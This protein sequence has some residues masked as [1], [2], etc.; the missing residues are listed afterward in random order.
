MTYR[1]MF[2][3]RSGKLMCWYSTNNIREAWKYVLY[4]SQWYTAKVEHVNVG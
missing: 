3:N 4:G 2:Y 1:V